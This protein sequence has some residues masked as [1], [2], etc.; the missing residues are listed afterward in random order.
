MDVV[1]LSS[2]IFLRRMQGPPHPLWWYV[3]V[4]SGLMSLGNKPLPEPVVANFYDTTWGR[5]AKIG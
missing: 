2:G 3:V 1:S 4:S 5:Q